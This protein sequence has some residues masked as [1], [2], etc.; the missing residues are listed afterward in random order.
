MVK[1]IITLIGFAFT[2]STLNSQDC[3][4]LPKI[5]SSYEQAIQE[6]KAS[7]FAIKKILIY[8]KAH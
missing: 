6:V 5:F 4:Q 3:N 1:N 8:L 7:N 2:L